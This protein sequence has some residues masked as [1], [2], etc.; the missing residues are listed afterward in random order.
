MPELGF[1]CMAK[2]HTPTRYGKPFTEFG[3]HHKSFAAANATATPPG[4]AMS[5]VFAT[6][7]NGEIAEG[8]PRKIYEIGRNMAFLPQGNM[9]LVR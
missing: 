3:C 4:I 5:I 1:R 9:S 6:P 2:P 8:L 7:K